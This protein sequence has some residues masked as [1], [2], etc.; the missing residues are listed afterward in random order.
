MSA[1][2]GNRYPP[3][4]QKKAGEKMP[5]GAA[6]P[7]ADFFIYAGVCEMNEM[8]LDVIRKKPEHPQVNTCSVLRVIALIV[9]SSPALSNGAPAERQQR[10]TVT[11][12]DQVIRSVANVRSRADMEQGLSGKEASSAMLFSWP[13]AERRAFWMRGTSRPL[14]VAFIDDA[15]VVQVSNMIPLTD[16]FHWSDIPVAQAFEIETTLGE[17]VG[18]TT[19]STFRSSCNELQANRISE[20]AHDR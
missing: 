14:T 11:I 5:S 13:T 7:W 10:C 9:I 16:D 19:G 4:A 8:N 20:T 6:T 17:K 2:E 12:N 15:K 1:P 18:L 3:V